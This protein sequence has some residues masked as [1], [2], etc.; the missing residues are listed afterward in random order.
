MARFAAALLGLVLVGGCSGEATT[1]PRT[2]VDQVLFGPSS[3]RLQPTFT[4]VRDWTGDGTPDGIEAVIELQDQFG[5][6]TKASGRVIFELY[7]YRPYNPDPR[8]LRLVAPWEGRL[9]SMEDQRA[10]W[11]RVNRAYIF[12]LAYPDARRDKDYVLEARFEL[13][14]GGRYRNVLIIEGEKPTTRASTPPAIPS[15]VPQPAPTP[16]NSQEPSSAPS[17]DHQPPPRTDQP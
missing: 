11:N 15:A 9:D 14:N 4:Q 13:A 16:G 17:I 6:P 5:D 2:N 12:Q 10:R 8:G 3:M 7:T 1:A